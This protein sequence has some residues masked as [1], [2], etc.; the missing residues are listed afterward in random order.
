[1]FLCGLIIDGGKV[2]LE[3]AVFF[4]FFLC[5]FVY[6][7]E[8]Y[9]FKRAE[10][11][12]ILRRWIGLLLLVILA[13]LLVACGDENNNNTNEEEA[14]VISVETDEVVEEDLVITRSVFGRVG[15]RNQEPVMVDGPG[16]VKELHV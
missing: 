8:R 14:A 16:E 11:L 13:G 5:G 4:F 6:D 9:D 7:R 2:P 1:I 12:V 10:V 3:W 15:L